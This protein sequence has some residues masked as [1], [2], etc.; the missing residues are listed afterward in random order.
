L[1]P[2]AS[3][4]PGYAIDIWVGVFAPAG[5]PPQLVERLNREINEI[6][7]SADL[8][9]V[10]EPEGTVPTAMSP[11]AFAARVKE[12]LAQWKQVA[13]AHKIVAE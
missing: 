9:V 7:A 13:A 1:P 3:A 11:A 5:T 4:V 8:A 10:L 12:E 2:L 6:S